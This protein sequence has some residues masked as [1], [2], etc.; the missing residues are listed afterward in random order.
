MQVG[1]VEDMRAR[2]A[3][4]RRAPAGPRQ[5]VEIAL[6][7]GRR[8]RLGAQGHQI[9]LVLMRHMRLQAFRRLARIA[10]ADRAAIDFAQHTL[11]HG[12]LA[13]HFDVLEHI[14]LE[15]DRHIALL[16]RPVQGA[17]EAIHHLIIILALKNRLHHLIAPLD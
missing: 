10:R 7:F 13:L 5:A 15:A 6:D 8:I 12:F 11:G 4:F 9:E 16:S 17:G 14:C 3:H 1:V 2:M